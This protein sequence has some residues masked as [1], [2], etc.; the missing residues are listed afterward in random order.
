MQFCLHLFKTQQR[1]PVTV[2]VA[3]ATLKDPLAAAF[4]LSLIGRDIDLMWR[5]FFHQRPP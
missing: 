1:V 2:W 3:L 5:F 4:G